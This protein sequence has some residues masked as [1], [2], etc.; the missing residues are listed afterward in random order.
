MRGCYI[1]KEDGGIPIQIERYLFSHYLNIYFHAALSENKE[2]SDFWKDSNTSRLEKEKLV[3]EAVE[4]YFTG[5]F[6]EWLEKK[7]NNSDERITFNRG[8]IPELVTTNR[9]LE[10]FSKP[11]ERRS[12]F[13]NEKVDLNFRTHTVLNDNKEIIGLFENFQFLLPFEVSI[14]RDN[15]TLIFE[16]SEFKLKLTI[17]TKGPQGYSLG[18]GLP[19]D[20]SKYYLGFTKNTAKGINLEITLS[21][22][23]EKPLGFNDFISDFESAF[24]AEKF[25]SDYDWESLCIQAR[26]VENILK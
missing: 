14:K 18:Y 19:V 4:Y 24:S 20:F 21:E 7:E 5:S 11:I 12:V 2:L 10:L 23:L 15:Q 3:T 25:F 6:L 16:S 17:H 22:S 9:F 8:N 26:M 13:I 1:I